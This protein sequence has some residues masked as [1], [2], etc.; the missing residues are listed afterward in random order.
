MH[1]SAKHQ[2][3][4]IPF[5]LL[6][7][8]VNLRGQ[9]KLVQVPLKRKAVAQIAQEQ[10][11]FRLFSEL[12]DRAEVRLKHAGSSGDVLPDAQ[13]DS[14]ELA[15]VVQLW[16]KMMADASAHDLEVMDNIDAM[17]KEGI[18]CVDRLAVTLHDLHELFQRDIESM[19]QDSF[20]GGPAN[21]GV[22]KM[23]VEE[24]A[25][26]NVGLKEQLATRGSGKGEGAHA[27]R[28]A[29]LE[30]ALAQATRERDDARRAARI[31]FSV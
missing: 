22:A 31:S 21:E 15:E 23:Q 29:E 8:T 10:R 17:Q 2:R 26:E 13:K 5:L 27:A 9:G 1:N 6:A 20:R 4:T 14:A 18:D 24:L 11:M 30:A 19:R 28:I 7:L 3:T 12:R 16:N 25:R